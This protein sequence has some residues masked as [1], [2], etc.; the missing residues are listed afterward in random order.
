MNMDRVLDLAIE[1]DASDIHLVA[2][3][4][5]ILRIARELIPIDEFGSIVTPKALSDY[6]NNK[7]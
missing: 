3:N 2:G 5:P 6:I 7:K 1:R 4:K